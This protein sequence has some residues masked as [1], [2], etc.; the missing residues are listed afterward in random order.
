M[1]VHHRTL[2][3]STSGRKAATFVVGHCAKPTGQPAGHY[4][5]RKLGQFLGHDNAYSYGIQVYL[6]R[7][8]VCC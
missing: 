7:T 3:L 1:S 4:G 5:A 2:A 6:K 8:E